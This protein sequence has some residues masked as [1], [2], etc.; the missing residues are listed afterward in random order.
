[1]KNVVNLLFLK[2]QKLTLEL[3]DEIL[4]C[5][6]SNITYNVLLSYISFSSYKKKKIKIKVSVKF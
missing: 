5:Y 1:M 2:C 3:V 4:W 6:H